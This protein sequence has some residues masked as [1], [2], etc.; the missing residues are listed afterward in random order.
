MKLI[1][2]SKYIGNI[3]FPKY[4]GRQHYMATTQG[5]SPSL[6]KHIREYEPIVKSLCERI[7]YKGVVH[8]T[9]DEK[10]LLAGE[11]QRKP[12][13]HI[14]GRFMRDAEGNEGWGSGW[15]HYCNEIPFERMSIA[16]ASSVSRCKVFHGEFVGQ[17]KSQGDCSHLSD[18]LGDGII[19]PKNQWH[20]LSPDCVHESLPMEVDC[21]RSF[22]RVAF[23]DRINL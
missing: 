12:H 13:P 15:N 17:P 7:G 3:K 2:K 4:N 8:I 11:T 1:S 9:V 23:E 6:P 14:D 22:I 18:Q 16:V 21:K 20:L 5:N 19:I 10:Q